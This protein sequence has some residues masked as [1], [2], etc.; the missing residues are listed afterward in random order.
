M[1]KINVRNAWGFLMNLWREN[2]LLRRRG[3][4]DVSNMTKKE[5]AGIVGMIQNLLKINVIIL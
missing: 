4:R 5:N 3:L 2:A 1:T